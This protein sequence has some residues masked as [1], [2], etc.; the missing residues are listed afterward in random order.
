MV[1]RAEAAAQEWEGSGRLKAG[2]VLEGRAE[3]TAACYILL[4][5]LSDVTNLLRED[6]GG[7]TEHG[8]DTLLQAIEAF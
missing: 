3:Q 1:K 2:G 5:F 4:G 6:G 8:I 7:V